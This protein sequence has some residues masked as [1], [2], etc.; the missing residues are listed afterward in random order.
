MSFGEVD[1]QRIQF[2]FTQ[3]VDDGA[4]L[5]Q[6]REHLGLRGETRESYFEIINAQFGE[7]IRRVCAAEWLIEFRQV[8]EQSLRGGLQI[9]NANGN[10]G[11][12]SSGR[13]ALPHLSL[14]FDA[15]E[16]RVHV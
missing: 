12:S 7:G 13:V 4:A 2:L 10:F 6:V 8:L 11:H 3:V 9:T 14:V 16:G 5:L 15:C 1:E